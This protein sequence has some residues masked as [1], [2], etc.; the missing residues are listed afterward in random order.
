LI[1]PSAP[2]LGV[3]IHWPYCARIC[4]YCDFAVVRARGRKDEQ[5]ALIDAI[6]ADLTAQAAMIGERRLVSIFLG[7]G[8]PSLMEPEAAGRLIALCRTLWPG[9]GEIEITL[10]A[11]PTDAESGRFAAFAA[12]GVNRL[13]LGVQALDNASLAFL[14]RNHGADEARRA[15]T[16]GGKVFPRLSLDLIY[17]LPGQ[18]E[19]QWRATLA[20]AAGFGAEHISPYQL[21]IEA[22]TPFDRA[23]RRGRFAPADP[24]GAGD[25]YEATQD[26]LT[27]LGFHAY[28]VSN[29]ARG[30]AARPRHN[31]IY[32]RGE[33]YLG[34][35]PSA[36]GRLTIDGDRI[37][38]ETPRAVSDY[39]ERVEDL[40][41]GVAWRETLTPRARAEE[42]LLMGLRTYE[43]VARSE[44]SALTLARLPELIDADLIAVDAQRL[45]ATPAGRLVLDR[46]TQMLAE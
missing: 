16:L 20:E 21:T 22:G 7:G 8:T 45:R 9:S 24:D 4:P 44:L 28:E 12:A 31:L 42:R 36:H 35:G 27:A 41:D 33:D 3:Y 25:L 29:H 6:A 14:G 15:A 40:G 19:A 17:A 46:V 32:W 5:A 18:T 11:N 26:A 10:E 1:E 30:E 34:V 39:I 37:A 38:T 2:P 23:V 43:G 13:S